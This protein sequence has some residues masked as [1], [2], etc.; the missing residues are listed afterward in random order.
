MLT[1]DIRLV[2]GPKDTKLA[3]W[4]LNNRAK[5]GG[6]KPKLNDCTLKKFGLPQ[7]VVVN[8]NLQLKKPKL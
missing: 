1:H 2:S 6:T 3:Q 5:M 8:G 7:T 4:L